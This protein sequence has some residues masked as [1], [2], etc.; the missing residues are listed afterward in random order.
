[1]ARS[2]RSAAARP[3]ARSIKHSRF[4]FRRLIFLGMGFL[5]ALHLTA[6]AALA[7]LRYVNPPT[8]GVQ[9]QRRIG[10]LFSKGE[11]RKRQTFVPL[12]RISAE[13]QHATIAAEDG[14]FYEH[15][16]IDWKQVRKVAEES[17]ESGE[18]ARG[19]S[20]ITQQLVKNLFFTTHRNPIRKA[21]EYTLAP[22]AD[23]ILGKQRTLELY[24]NVVEWGP[25]V[26]GAEAAAQYHF[27]TAAARLSRDQAARLAAV[28]PAP[29]RRKP[30]RMDRYSASIQSRMQQMGW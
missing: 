5:V 17:R 14:R 22:M 23:A 24:L 18:I 11:Y 29:Q 21:L 8:T 27:H 9:I 3:A 28:L 6:A 12:N 20:T 2:S 13:L 7:L 30:A 1:V 25:G 10:S 16:G 4:S 15:H 26:Y 19:A